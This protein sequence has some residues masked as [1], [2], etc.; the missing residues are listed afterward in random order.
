[1][2]KQMA[3]KKSKTASAVRK[4]NRSTPPKVTKGRA[5]ALVPPSRAE[6]NG[7]NGTPGSRPK[8]KN[9]SSGRP[10]SLRPR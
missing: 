1:V 10:A 2:T 8:A 7:A 5:L 6:G 9:I 4:S 3:K